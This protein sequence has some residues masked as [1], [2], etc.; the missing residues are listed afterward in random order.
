LRVNLKTE[1][2][3][4]PFSRS[5]CATFIYFEEC[6]LPATPQFLPPR[7]LT[8]LRPASALE[9]TLRDL[10]LPVRGSSGLVH[11]AHFLRTVH[12]FA[13]WE[14]SQRTPV[15]DITTT[16]HCAYQKLA[17]NR[18]I[19]DTGA[20]CAQPKH[21]RPETALRIQPRDASARR[22]AARLTCNFLH[23][24]PGFVFTT[25]FRQTGFSEFSPWNGTVS[26]AGTKGPTKHE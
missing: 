13:H 1:G 18:K 15:R 19:R 26:F 12:S 10:Y 2:Q 20:S 25:R 22:R 24:P 16:N 17:S 11:R 8:A 6:P 3:S 23:I 7:H 21:S 9:R 5:P 14:N 4:V